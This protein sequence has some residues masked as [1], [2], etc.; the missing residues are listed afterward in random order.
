MKK[1]LLALILVLFA[2]TA[3]AQAA[4][5]LVCSPA[6]ATDNVTQSQVTVNGT[7]GVWVTYTTAT[8]D[9]TVY[10]VLQD[11]ASLANGNYTVTAKFKNQWGESASSIPFTFTKGLPSA[12]SGMAI[13]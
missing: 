11:L 7:A 9:G 8:I 5:R 6:I 4:P 1:I 10:C 13:K 12:P 3:M 2:S